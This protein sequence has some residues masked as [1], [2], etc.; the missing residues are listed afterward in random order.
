MRDIKFRIWDNEEKTIIENKDIYSLDFRKD[1]YFSSVM[2]DGIITEDD[3]KL[4]Q[5]TGLKDKN[6]K[7]IY[8]G[9]IL[10]YG[11]S[12]KYKVVFSKSTFKIQKVNNLKGDLYLLEDCWFDESEVIGTIYEN[13]ELLK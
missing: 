9:D 2:V 10:D 11:E 8:E 3:Y 13:L 12:G 6:G 1:I 7:E 4:M 5:Y